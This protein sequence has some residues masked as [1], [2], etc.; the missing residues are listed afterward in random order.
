REELGKLMWEK[1]GIV[2][3]GTKL[4]QA[5]A[6]IA[7]L[8]RRAEQVSASGGRRFN[9]GWQQALDLRNLLTASELIARSALLREESRGA[10]FRSD[11]ERTDNAQWLRNIYLCRDGTDVKSWSVPVR[12]ERLRP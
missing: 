2:R 10:H 3:D 11:F 7:D 1:V 5:L 9:L 8:T 4:N 12:A 6:G